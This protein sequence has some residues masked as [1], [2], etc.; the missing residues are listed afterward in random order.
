[1][2]TAAA[3]GCASGGSTP[4]SQQEDE[5]EEEGERERE[6]YIQECVEV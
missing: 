2:R 6:M 1:M 4:Y 3:R 5:E